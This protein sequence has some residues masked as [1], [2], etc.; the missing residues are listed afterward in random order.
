MKYKVIAH[1]DFTED[2]LGEYRE[3]IPLDDPKDV[4][5]ENKERIKKFFKELLGEV[6]E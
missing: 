2:L 1:L 3:I 6:E 4:T 5:D